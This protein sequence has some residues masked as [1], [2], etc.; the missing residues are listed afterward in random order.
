M[1]CSSCLFDFNHLAYFLVA[2]PQ[3]INSKSYT[4]RIRSSKTEMIHF[5]LILT[6]E[7][8]CLDATSA[9]RAALR[10]LFNSYYF[11]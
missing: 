4:A 7:Y 8:L 6:K 2:P 3:R 11:S 5:I 10:K 1:D 9:I